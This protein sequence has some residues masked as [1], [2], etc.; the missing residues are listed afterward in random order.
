MGVAAIVKA[1]HACRAISPRTNVKFQCEVRGAELPCRIASIR[2]ESHAKVVNSPVHF[3]AA[4]A[5]AR[6]R[7]YSA[8]ELCG[9]AQESLVP[10]LSREEC[11]FAALHDG[12]H[13][14]YNGIVID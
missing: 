2:H 5:Q 8:I 6:L 3:V 9:F 14:F 4:L 7:V 1:G 10:K 13:S 12:N 11:F